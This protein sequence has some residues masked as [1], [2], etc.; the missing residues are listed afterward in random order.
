MNAREVV[1]LALES[2]MARP[3]F[4][5]AGEALAATSDAWLPS[6]P[7]S[8]WCTRCGRSAGTSRVSHDGSAGQA[9]RS[10]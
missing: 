10:Q 3:A 6:P 8:G 9:P 2:G 7:Q 4:R 5:G 1:G